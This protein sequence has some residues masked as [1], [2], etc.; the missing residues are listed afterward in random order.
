MFKVFK[1]GV[2]YPTHFFNMK[3]NTYSG[4]KT[5]YHFI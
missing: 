2:K 3:I 1:G 5:S 4:P